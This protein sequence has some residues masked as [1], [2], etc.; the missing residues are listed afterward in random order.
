MVSPVD[1][2]RSYQGSREHPGAR[3][4]HVGQILCCTFVSKAVKMGS[5]FIRE[6]GGGRTGN[7]RFWAAA[8][9]NP[10]PGGSGKGSPRGPA[11]F[12]PILTPADQF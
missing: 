11:R 12:A 4:S 8:R 3:A 9:S 2:A 5:G 10:T 7:H 6:G 1:G